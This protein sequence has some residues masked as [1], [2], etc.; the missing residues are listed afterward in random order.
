MSFRNQA[1]WVA[2]FTQS[3]WDYIVCIFQQLC[4]DTS[5]TIWLRIS[6]WMQNWL[7]QGTVRS[8]I[9]CILL[10]QIRI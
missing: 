6:I 2:Q 10:I 9:D 5:P 3:V 4:V 8:I 7:I 1:T